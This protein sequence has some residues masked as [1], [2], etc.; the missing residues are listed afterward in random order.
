MEF[1]LCLAHS[2]S[3]GPLDYSICGYFP[4]P[5]CIMG[6]D[7]CRSC[8]KPCCDPSCF[9]LCGIE[10]LC[11]VWTGAHGQDLLRTMMSPKNI[12]SSVRPLGSVWFHGLY[13]KSQEN[14]NSRL[15]WKD[16]F[17]LCPVLLVAW[18]L[19]VWFSLPSTHRCLVWGSKGHLIIHSLSWI[20]SGLWEGA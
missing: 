1:W 14:N 18:D 6:V 7:I 2:W 9:T 10:Y 17:C 8:Q 11:R 4:V 13:L 15:S 5:K 19:R 3:S 12:L 20:L 16:R